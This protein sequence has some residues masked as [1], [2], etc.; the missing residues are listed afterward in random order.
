MEKQRKFPKKAKILLGGLVLLA[1]LCLVFKILNTGDDGHYSA[2][3]NTQVIR[4]VGRDG[5]ITTAVQQ[6]MI[7]SECGSY[8]KAEKTL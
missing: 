7:G 5:K 1:V 4:S 3:T 8:E 6:I 2:A